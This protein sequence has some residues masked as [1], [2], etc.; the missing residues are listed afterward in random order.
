MLDIVCNHGSPAFTMPVAQPQFGQ[1][2]DRD[3]RLV[4]DHQNLPPDRL[5]PAHN[6]L[7]AFYNTSG[8]LVQPVRSQREQPG[9]AGLPG[10]RHTQWLEQGADA[11]RIDTI[12][13][14]PDT[15]WRAF[16]ARIRERRPGFFM[17]GE[18]FDYDAAAIAHHTWP[19]GG[20]R[21]C[22]ISR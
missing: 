8:N 3:G 18:D 6:P 7:H 19:E 1:I 11:F 17:F 13:W 22:W 14:M 16:A 5:D 2:F 21:W 20:A 15:F 9:R 10:R 4:A 12:R